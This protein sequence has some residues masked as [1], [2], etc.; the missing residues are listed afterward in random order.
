MALPKISVDSG[1]TTNQ[2]FCSCSKRI[3]RRQLGVISHALDVKDLLLGAGLLA[4]L[5]SSK[6]NRSV[7]PLG[8][9]S[10]T[11]TSYFL[12][13]LS[14][15]I[16]WVVSADLSDSN[17]LPNLLV[18]LLTLSCCLSA[19]SCSLSSALPAILNL[20]FSRP[21]SH[22]TQNCTFLTPVRPMPRGVS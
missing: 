18:T 20:I 10:V 14:R 3:L 19:P 12:Q 17:M 1:V 8:S 5:D 7:M 21:S 6:P 4:P 2:P 16:S 22:I 11:S 9:P 13:S 15:L